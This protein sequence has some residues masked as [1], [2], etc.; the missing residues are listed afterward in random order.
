MV[1][2]RNRLKTGITNPQSSIPG[3]PHNTPIQPHGHHPAMIVHL[4]SGIH[5]SPRVCLFASYMDIIKFTRDFVFIPRTLFNDSIEGFRRDLKGP[6]RNHHRVTPH[7]AR[8]TTEHPDR[9]YI[10]VC[11]SVISVHVSKRMLILLLDRR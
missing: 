3:T 7:T 11:R 9:Y 8:N 2:K 1:W 4:F 5:P 10:A 6:S